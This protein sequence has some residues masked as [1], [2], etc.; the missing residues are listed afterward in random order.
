MTTNNNLRPCLVLTH[1]YPD[2]HRKALFHGWVLKT[3]PKDKSQEPYAL[4]EL[5]AGLMHLVQY[6]RVVFMDN[7]ERMA[8]MA[9][10]EEMDEEEG[11]A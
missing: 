7:E 5:D 10:P 4:V 3:N 1:Y 9:W 11:E 6:D 2:P 8:Q